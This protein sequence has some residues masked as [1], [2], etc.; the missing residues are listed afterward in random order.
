VERYAESQKAGAVRY[1]LFSVADRLRGGEAFWA[2]LRDHSPTFFPADTVAMVRAGEKSGRLGKALGNVVEDLRFYR[3]VKIRFTFTCLYLFVVVAVVSFWATV[4]VTFVLPRFAD[5]W[6]ETGTE[7][8]A[9][10]RF[11]VDPPVVEIWGRYMGLTALVLPVLVIGIFLFSRFLFGVPAWLAALVPGL[12]GAFLRHQGGRYLSAL[13]MYLDSNTPTDRAVTAAAE[14]VRPGPFRRRAEGA[15]SRVREG[16]PV[17]EALREIRSLREDL[18]WRI[19]SAERRGNLPE[20]LLTLG[21]EEQ[22]AAHRRFLYFLAWFRPLSIVVLGC[23]ELAVALAGYLPLF[24]I[25]DLIPME[26]L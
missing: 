20:T 1:A 2:A 14:A 19:R 23:I 9:V 25:A 12:R 18:L 16:E 24:Q 3:E 17:G 13:G 15:A 4:L 6:D 11:F 8:P 22:E 26:Y 7:L 5:F 10:T 21:I